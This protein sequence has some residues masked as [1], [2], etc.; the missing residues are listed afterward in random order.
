MF[1]PSENGA[2]TG[3]TPADPAAWI[4]SLAQ[5]DGRDLRDAERIDQIRELEQLKAAAA[6]A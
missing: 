1:D 4:V 2:P 5:H 3:S 6:A